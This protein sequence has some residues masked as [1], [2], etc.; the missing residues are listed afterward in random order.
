MDTQPFNSS[1]TPF[2]PVN[3]LIVDPIMSMNG[4]TGLFRQLWGTQSGNSCWCKTLAIVGDTE[5]TESF[6]TF[7][8][9]EYTTLKT[10]YN[11]VKYQS[12]T[13][14]DF[15]PGYSGDEE[16]Y[17][18]Q[19]PSANTDPFFRV[20]ATSDDLDNYI[21]A[22]DYGYASPDRT[23]SSTE[24]DRLCGGVV[25]PDD[26]FTNA[27][28]EVD[29]RMNITWEGD[30]RVKYAKFL[31]KINIYQDSRGLLKTA[32]RES[33]RQWYMAQGFVGL[34]LFV[35]RFLRTHHDSL[36]TVT[37]PG[38]RLDSSVDM[39]F[40]QVYPFPG[41]AYDSN[42]ALEFLVN[43]QFVLLFCFSLTVA[44][45]IGRIVRE[46]ELK[47]REYMRMMGLSDAAYYASWIFVMVLTWAWIAFGITVMAFIDAFK[48][49][50]FIM[51]FFFNFLFGLA[52]MSFSFFISALCTRE[53]LGSI[54]GFFLFFLCQAITAPDY[55][56]TTVSNLIS[57]IP[58]SAYMMGVRTMF[59]LESM[60]DGVTSATVN[61]K[62]YGYSMGQ[63]YL[64]LTIDIFLWYALFYYADQVNP[65][66]IGYRRKWYFPFTSDYWRDL[67]GLH[68]VKHEP[69]VEQ[70][71]NV[72]AQFEKITDS[73]LLKLEADGKCI[74]TMQ[75]TR[76]FGSWFLAVD[77]LN[78]TMYSDEIYALL[79][80][81]GA[82]KTTTFSMLTGMLPPSSGG[83]SAFGWA[84]PKDMAE[85]R[86]SMG[87][88]PQ[89]SSLWDE[90]TVMEHMYIFAC[91]RGLDWKV[92]EP[93]L[94]ALLVEV[95]LSGRGNFQVK[96][97]SGGMKRKLS[98][99]IAFVGDPKI[100]FL[101]EPTSGMDPFAR[102]ATWDLL[103]RK[104]KGRVICLTTHYMD[105]ADVLGDRIAIMANGRLECSGSSMFLK[106]LYGC[107]YLISFVKTGVEDS[108]NEKIMRY[109]KSHLP[110]T[111][112]IRV[113]SSIGREYIVEVDDNTDGFGDMLEGLDSDSV[114]KDIQ[115]QSYGISVT[116][117]EEVFLKVANSTI[118]HPT[119]TRV[120]KETPRPPHA[121]SFWQQFIALLERRLRYGLRDRQLFFMQIFLP[122]LILVAGLGFLLAAINKT[123]D[124]LLL[125]V[126][127]LNDNG[128][129]LVRITPQNSTIEVDVWTPYCLNAAESS[130]K[131][132]Q[133]ITPISNAFTPYD[134]QTVLLHNSSLPGSTDWAYTANPYFAYGNF[135]YIDPN[136]NNNNNGSSNRNCK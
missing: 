13:N 25:F 83:I 108:I 7:M 65:F 128:E 101:D 35:Q 51:V 49:S 66:L 57:L 119:E 89:H 14:Y 19:C 46:R 17:W 104:R 90:L 70:K 126:E 3:D 112:S 106:K 107:G 67:F 124:P 45:T 60:S 100:V 80:H 68:H 73:N 136:Q 99:G 94:K 61:T 32:G 121:V 105:E 86:R 92:I 63:A 87:V 22:A 98:V 8:E 77:K 123:A 88:C 109:L 120:E 102:R 111:D 36:R 72:G 117:I 34:Q 78:L 85:L 56:S 130:T 95:G 133:L 116:N 113:V 31:T 24:T 74:K 9:T 39:T 2:Q 81:N 21:G 27:F 59:L 91:I 20:F 79:G 82:G 58:P 127:P 129:N 115:I 30:S 1:A 131:C 37:T 6:K 26:V 84:I 15:V 125:S 62:I 54:I 50:S 40:W 10:Y 64:M 43:M 5:V 4:G 114:K 110:V 38:S 48:A 12:F 97:L 23:Q 29:L 41:Y 135:I 118:S 134:F 122:F 28:P 75:L 44:L 71:E 47:L 93:S 69:L 132:S 103:K 16:N 33:A 53:R 76:R 42:E 55:S 52:S 96:A 11:D 18:V